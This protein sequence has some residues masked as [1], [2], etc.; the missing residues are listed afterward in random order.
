MKN[1]KNINNQLLKSYK[2]LDY[3]NYKNNN[4]HLKYLRK[5]ELENYFT[6]KRFYENKY[7]IDK[8]NKLLDYKYDSNGN[9]YKFNIES[10]RNN[11][12]DLTSLSDEELINH[13]INFGY[14]E[15]RLFCEPIKEFD[16]KYYI[17]NNLDIKLININYKDIL[18]QWRHYLYHGYFEGKTYNL[19][20]KNTYLI[21]NNA[22]INEKT[23]IIYVYYNRPGEYKN[24]TNLAFFINQT[25]KKRDSIKDNIEFLFIINN[26]NCEVKIPEQKNVHIL[27]NQN[28]FDFEAYIT[29]IRYIENIYSN[30][31]DRLYNYVMFMNCSCTGPFTKNNNF[32]LKPFIDKLDKNTVCCTSILTLITIKSYISGPQIPG[33]LF[34]IKSNYIHLLIKPN[35]ILKNNSDFSNTV[36]GPKKNKYDCI[37][38]GEHCISILLLQHNL[39]IAGI[40]N[41]NLDYRQK[42]N[43]IYL[44]FN[45]D[46]HPIFNFSLYQSIFIKNNWRIDNF[47]RDSYPVM[48]SQT[49]KEIENLNNMLFINYENSILDYNL[50]CINNI[51]LVRFN[52][53]SWKSKKDFGNKFSES[54]ELITFPN[55]DCIKI[56]NYYHTCNINQDKN[57]VERYIIEGIKSLLYLNYKIN[58]YTNLNIPFNF[59]ISNNINI[60]YNISQNDIKYDNQNLG[61]DLL[62]PCTDFTTFKE[63]LENNKFEKSIIKIK[64][65]KNNIDNYCNNKYIN[66]LTMYW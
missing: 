65:Y 2:N 25:I 45:G 37:I 50:L 17:K 43:Y 59:K 62:F 32:W 61:S 46:R 57:E 36:L 18:N 26:F 13:F 35:N 21:Y 44:K 3:I 38:S 16:Y 34:L 58:F 30:N 20:H 8:L 39:N 63:E 31:I 22:I 48:W 55:S 51:G 11:N 60:I 14:N 49:K 10:Y 54:E 52:K 41:K 64:D 5:N 40:C 24:E 56:I 9:L 28:C 53:S 47:S 23:L 12:K 6:K 33:Y 4:L 29:G 42:K 1:N 27:K 7:F 19:N 15:K 66:F